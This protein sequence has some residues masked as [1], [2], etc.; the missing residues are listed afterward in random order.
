MVKRFGVPRFACVLGVLA[1]AGPLSAQEVVD[2]PATDRY[3]PVDFEGVFRVGALDG[4]DWE[5]FG[6]IEGLAFDEA[7]NLYVFDRQSS[8]VVVV[9]PQGVFLREIGQ[10]GEGPGELRMPVTFTVLRDGTVIVADI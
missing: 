3:L 10:P 6:E 2:L 9:D 5:T 4:E 8:R 1:F 7:G